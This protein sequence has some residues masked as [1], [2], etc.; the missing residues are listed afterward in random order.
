MIKLKRVK[1]APIITPRK[2]VW[3][4]MQSVF[5]PAV[6]K[7]RGK[8]VMLYRAVGPER[9]SRFGYADSKNGIHFKNFKNIPVFESPETSIYERLGCEDPRITQIGDTYY[10]VYTGASLYP[11]KK[12]QYMY[13]QARAPWRTRVMLLTTKNFTTFTHHGVM[14]KHTDS[15]NGTMF[16]G[17]IGDKY[18][19]LH[20]VFP[21]ISIAFSG[22]LKTWEDHE[23][24]MRPRSRK[25]DSSRIGAGATPILTKYG[26]LLFYHATDKNKVYRLGLAVLDKN[27]P[28]KIIYRSDQ[29]IFEPELS[30]EKKGWIDNVV[31]TCGAIDMDGKY[32]IYYGAADQSI[33]VATIEK[34]KLFTEIKNNI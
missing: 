21:N 5:N 10:I 2:S 11:A 15:K 30:F 16:P 28:K 32:Y 27:D 14:V 9:I 33:A 12:T 26:W 1:N 7:Y 34:E 25:W 22:D 17:K 31:F 24:L 18:A 19:L 8:I 29:P 23:I 6:A 3:W 13:S 4:E 20:R